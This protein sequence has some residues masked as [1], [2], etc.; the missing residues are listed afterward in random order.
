MNL[1]FIF[2]KFLYV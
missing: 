1:I 2:V